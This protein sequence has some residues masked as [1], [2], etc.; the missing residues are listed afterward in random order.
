MLDQDFVGVLLEVFFVLFLSTILFDFFA[1]DASFFKTSKS[2]NINCKKELKALENI[3]NKK[4]KI[5]SFHRPA[6]FLLSYN[7]KIAGLNHSYMYKYTKNIHYCSDSQG[8]W[9]FDTPQNILKNNNKKNFTLQL[10]THLIWWTTPAKLNAAEKIDFHLKKKYD[11]SK[12][13]AAKNC[14]PFSIYLKN[15]I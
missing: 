1:F 11:S 14:K 4:I 13:I 5:I 7:Q 3:I 6:R 15:K 8:S 12:K 10:L 9:R 2:L